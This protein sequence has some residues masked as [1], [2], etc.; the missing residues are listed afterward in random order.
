MNQTRRAFVVSPF[1]V[2]LRCFTVHRCL[3]LFHRS[4]LSYV[5]SP[6]TVVLRCFTVHH[7]LT[8]SFVLCS[9]LEIRRNLQKHHFKCFYGSPCLCS[10]GPA[11]A[12]IEDGG[13]SLNL[14]WKLMFILDIASMVMATLVLSSFVEVPPLLKLDAR[15]FNE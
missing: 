8:H 9:V 11:L 10:Q 14:I 6:F 12:S 7:C 4:P 3:T 15:Y 13:Y 1:T 2:V 5:V